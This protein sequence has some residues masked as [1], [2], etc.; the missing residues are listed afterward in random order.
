VFHLGGGLPTPLLRCLFAIWPSRPLVARNDGTS[1]RR[2]RTGRSERHSASGAGVVGS[3]SP[4]QPKRSAFRSQ[5]TAAGRRIEASPTFAIS[6][7]PSDSSVTTG[8][9]RPMDFGRSEPQRACQSLTREDSRGRRQHCS[10][11][12]DRTSLPVEQFCR[13][14]SN[15]ADAPEAERCLAFA[16]HIAT[17]RALLF[18]VSMLADTVRA[19]ECANSP[20]CPG[21]LHRILR[22]YRSYE[23]ATTYTRSLRTPMLEK[24]AS[25][26]DA[27][28]PPL[29]AEMRRLAAIARFDAGMTDE[30]L[31]ELRTLAEESDHHRSIRYLPLRLSRSAG[32]GMSLKTGSATMARVV[33]RPALIGREPKIES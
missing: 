29:A 3:S 2:Y 25:D 10:E 28:C 13:E 18:G 26:F 6:L 32:N 12:G 20:A 16:R 22:G 33:P 1:G 9:S 5:P 30:S 7:R 31:D 21:A 19:I 8:G 24:A 23:V 14:T 17:A 15:V 11:L 4:R 27:A